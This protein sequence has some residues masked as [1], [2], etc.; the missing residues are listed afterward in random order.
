MLFF[1]KRINEKSHKK[2]KAV[3]TTEV[4]REIANRLGLTEQ[5]GMIMKNCLK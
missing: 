1:T 3:Y 5:Q 2:D 4:Y